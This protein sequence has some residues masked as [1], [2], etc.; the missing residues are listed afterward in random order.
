MIKPNKKSLSHNR[1]ISND[2]FDDSFSDSVSLRV[3]DNPGQMMPKSSSLTPCLP[4]C[5]LVIQPSFKYINTVKSFT[6]CL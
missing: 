5:I 6:I 4:Y 1:D 2:Y 3:L